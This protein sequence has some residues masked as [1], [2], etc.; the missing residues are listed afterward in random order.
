MCLKDLERQKDEEKELKT[1]VNLSELKEN[2]QCNSYPVEMS[3]ALGSSDPL[4]ATLGSSCLLYSAGRILNKLG[5][6]TNQ[7][8]AITYHNNE[9]GSGQ[10][11]CDTPQV[12]TA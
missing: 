3:L 11:K 2:I 4:F 12:V 9:K 10:K 6:D 7:L 1:T 8:D 5:F